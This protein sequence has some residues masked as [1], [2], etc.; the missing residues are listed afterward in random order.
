LN[1]SVRVLDLASGEELAALAIRANPGKQNEAQSAPPEYPSAPELLATALRQRGRG[2][3][4]KNASTLY[5]NAGLGTTGPPL[6][7]GVAPEI[8]LVVLRATDVV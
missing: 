5:V 3:F 1:A 2:L 6:R 4:R 7:L 8:A